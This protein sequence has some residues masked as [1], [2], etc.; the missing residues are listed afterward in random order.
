MFLTTGDEL[1]I[2]ELAP[3]PH[4]SFHETELACPTSQFE[5][6]VRATVASLQAS[7]LDEPASVRPRAA[8]KSKT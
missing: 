3:R 6:L 4:N 1:L 7:A 5:Q 8:S 2:N